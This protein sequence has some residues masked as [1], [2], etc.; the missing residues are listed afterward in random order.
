MS[1]DL[2]ERGQKGDKIGYLSSNY[3]CWAWVEEM[4][5][6]KAKVCKFSKTIMFIVPTTMKHHASE[7]AAIKT[8]SQYLPAHDIV[9]HTTVIT[10]PTM[11]LCFR[12]IYRTLLYCLA[13]FLDHFTSLQN[14]F[15]FHIILLRE[16]FLWEGDIF[17][18]KFCSEETMCYSLLLS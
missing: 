5:E 11:V 12:S 13:S 15:F 3:F 4:K 2:M 1:Q 8:Y 17:E 14:F 9:A 10:T 18:I 6:I 7:H 16:R